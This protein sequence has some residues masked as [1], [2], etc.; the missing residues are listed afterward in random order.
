MEAEIERDIPSSTQVETLIVDEATQ[1]QTPD[2]DEEM[3]YPPSG[4]SP[5]CVSAPNGAAAEAEEEEEKEEEETSAP[6]VRFA[7]PP[8]PPYM[9]HML[10]VDDGSVG[11]DIAWFE[12][13]LAECAR[14]IQQYESG[15]LTDLAANYAEESDSDARERIRLAAC[16]ARVTKSLIDD[17]ATRRKIEEGILEDGFGQWY[18]SEEKL[19]TCALCGRTWDGN[20]QCFPCVY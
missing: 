17:P 4:H 9:E 20:A 3:P 19:Y 16:E 8:P 14:A 11:K 6:V 5:V 1:V 13:T 15:A 18:D 12:A 7:S 2:E 10:M